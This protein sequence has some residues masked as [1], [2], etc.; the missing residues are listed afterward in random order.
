VAK[1]LG[2]APTKMLVSVPQRTLNNPWLFHG[3]P[4]VATMI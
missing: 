1:P 4:A 2:F 3:G